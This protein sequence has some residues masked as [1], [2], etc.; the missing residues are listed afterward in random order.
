MEGVGI[1]LP[2]RDLWRFL[3]SSF[4]RDGFAADALSRNGR[5]LATFAFTQAACSIEADGRMTD[6]VPRARLSPRHTAAFLPA[7]RATFCH[8]FDALSF[9]LFLYLAFTIPLSGMGFA[10][11]MLS[12][13]PV[14]L[15][16]AFGTLLYAAF[17]GCAVAVR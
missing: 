13:M 9:S 10:L 8:A 4:L 15:R 3:L 6:V 16:A 17:A 5:K 7:R 14:L 2:R 1:I 12:S 11:P